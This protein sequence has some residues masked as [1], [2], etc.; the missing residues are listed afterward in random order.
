VKVP[1][2]RR[3]AR[4]GT[5]A[6]A[7]GRAVGLSNRKN[8]GGKS[9]AYIYSNGMLLIGELNNLCLLTQKAGV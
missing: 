9:Q 4:P 6:G 8:L 7:A 1:G 5:G 2:R 3:A